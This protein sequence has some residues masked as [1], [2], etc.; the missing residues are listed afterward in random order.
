M[1]NSFWF[2]ETSGD[3][4][5][6]VPA[7]EPP[8]DIEESVRFDGQ[9][10]KL[11]RTPSETDGQRKGE[12]GAITNVAVN[13]DNSQT[14]TVKDGFEPHQTLTGEYLQVG[15]IITQGGGRYRVTAV[16]ADGNPTAADAL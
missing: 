11:T 4:P 2:S 10:N 13:T 5:I 6:K 3:G 12:T 1:T 14:L 8:Y 15:D 9:N 7:Q 16:D